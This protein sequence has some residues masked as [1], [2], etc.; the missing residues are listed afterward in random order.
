MKGSRA[1]K[2]TL[3]ALCALGPA[4]FLIKAAVKPEGDI[5]PIPSAIPAMPVIVITVGGVSPADLEGARS[6]LPMPNTTALL[7]HGVQFSSSLSGAPAGAPFDISVLTGSFPPDHGVATD[8]NKMNPSFP[9]L[10]TEIARQSAEKRIPFPSAAFINSNLGTAAGVQAGFEQFKEKPGVAATELAAD[11]DTWL[12]AA[13]PPRFF[14]WLDFGDARAAGDRRAALLKIDE[15]I[16]NITKML[17]RRRISGD[18]LLMLATDPGPTKLGGRDTS[19]SAPTGVLGIQLPYDYKIGQICPIALSAVDLAP[20]ALEMLRMAAPPA[21]RGRARAKLDIA[22]F[23]CTG[24]AVA[25]PFS[26]VDAGDVWIARQGAQTLWS[27]AAGGV[28]LFVDDA[29]AQST[30]VPASLLS[31]AVAAAAPRNR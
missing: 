22:K 8:T 31:A 25:G 3:Y 5:V 2:L 14:A 21:W 12:G 24:P 30:T 18:C 11:F 10:A 26:T 1:S 27:T 17:R 13:S 20:T 28:L 16:G 7:R 9:T 6:A 19:W 23:V 4:V 15:A 29:N